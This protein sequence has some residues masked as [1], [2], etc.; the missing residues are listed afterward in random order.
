MWLKL[1]E[2]S[3]PQSALGCTR[4]MGLTGWVCTKKTKATS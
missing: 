3:H 1:S 4:S 2:L